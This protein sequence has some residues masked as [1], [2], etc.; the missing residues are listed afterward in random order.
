M[1]PKRLEKAVWQGR[2]AIFRARTSQLVLGQ[3]E[4]GVGDGEGFVIRRDDGTVVS[5]QG[6]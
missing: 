5:D 6:R 3:L 2:G 1:G 4:R